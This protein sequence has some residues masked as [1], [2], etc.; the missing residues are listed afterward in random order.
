MTEDLTPAE[1]AAEQILTN[2]MPHMVGLVNDSL[3]RLIVAA[4]EPVIA[5]ERDKYMKLTQQWRQAA[6]EGVVRDIEEEDEDA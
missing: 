3:A 5:A 4:V 6:L 1:K 2:S